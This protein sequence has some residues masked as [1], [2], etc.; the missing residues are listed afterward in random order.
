VSLQIPHS[1][2]EMQE[3]LKLVSQVRKP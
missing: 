2:E 3:L 1:P